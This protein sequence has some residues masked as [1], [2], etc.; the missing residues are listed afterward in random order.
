MMRA[1]HGTRA[2]L[3]S[4]SPTPFRLR[5][6]SVRNVPYRFPQIASRNRSSHSLSVPKG[7]DSMSDE[8]AKEAISRRGFLGMGSAALAAAGL[9]SAADAAGQAQQQQPYP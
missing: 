4:S 7:E 8:A 9:I 3:F 2:F 5:I 6:D 1:G